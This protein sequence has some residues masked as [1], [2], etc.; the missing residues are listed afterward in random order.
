MQDHA[1]RLVGL[2]GL[3]V[4]EVQRTGEQLDLQVGLNARAASCTH[5]EGTELRVQ[6]RPLVR[7]LDLPNAGR[8]TRLAWRKRRYRCAN[9]ARTF[10]ETH[11][12]LPHPPARDDTLPRGWPSGSPTV[13]RT[14]RSHARSARAATRSRRRSPPYATAT[15][16]LDSTRAA[17]AFPRNRQSPAGSS[18]G[19]PFLPR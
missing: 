14:P 5:C 18:T 17:V 13:P 3:V 1:N 4:T 6:E 16:E 11:D 8:L 19:G 7:V 12:Q 10:T 2:D 9:C 15:M